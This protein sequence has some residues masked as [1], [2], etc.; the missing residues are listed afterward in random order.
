MPAPA[1][2]LHARPL[3]VDVVKVGVG[4][5]ALLERAGG[6]AQVAHPEPRERP[7]VAPAAARVR[8]AVAAG[9]VAHAEVGGSLRQ[10]WLLVGKGSSEDRLEV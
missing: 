3:V 4:E 10:S 5:R 8:P 2:A 9:V 6:A 1:L 7:V